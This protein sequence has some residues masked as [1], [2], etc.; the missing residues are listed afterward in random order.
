[1]SSGARSPVSVV[2]KNPEHPPQGRVGHSVGELGAWWA[3]PCAHLWVTEAAPGPQRWARS[4]S[5]ALD[6]SLRSELG[7]PVRALHLSPSTEA[8]G[9]RGYTDTV[10]AA[11]RP[12]SRGQWSL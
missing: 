11:G 6:R 1:M 4:P 7:F 2:G 12:A 5:P 9:A 8:C 3:N 10:T